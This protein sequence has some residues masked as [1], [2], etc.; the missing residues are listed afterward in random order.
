MQK[1]AVDISKDFLRTISI[2]QKT[3]SRNP[4]STVATQ[5]EIPLIIYACCSPVSGTPHCPTCGKKIEQQSAQQIVNTILFEHAGSNQDQSVGTLLIAAEKANTR[6]IG[7]QIA[8]SGFARMR[9]NRQE[10][11]RQA[12]L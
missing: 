9:I 2:E 8:R 10:S 6:N 1:P 4:R 3:V 5:T 7:K 11:L 12:I